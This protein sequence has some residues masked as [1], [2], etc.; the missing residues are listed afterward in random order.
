MA[1]KTQVKVRVRRVYDEPRDDDGTRVLVD[2]LWPRGLSKDRAALDEWCKQV[3]PSTELRTWYRHDPG[4][5]AEF[6]RRY[7]GELEEPERAE[8]V[9]HLRE[10]AR[11]GVLTLLTATRQAEISEAAVL[12]EVLQE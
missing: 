6:A 9:A 11:D 12:A 1:G 5:F 10:L 4:L 8:A 2:R 7:R 3:A